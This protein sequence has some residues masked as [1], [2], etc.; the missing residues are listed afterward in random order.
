M[1]ISYD[2]YRVFYYVAQ[3]GNLSKAA[4]CLYSNQPNLTRAIKALESELGCP[5]FLRSNRGMRL[6]PEGERLYAHVRAAFAH[7][8]AG[9]AEL[10][11]SRDLESGTV[12]VAAS[13]VALRCVLLPVLRQYRRLYPGIRL[14]ISNHS[15]PQAIAALRG[16][17]ADIAVVTTPTVHEATLVE[18]PIRPFSEVA[19]CGRA[20][21]EL[22]GRKVS[23]AE[24]LSYPLVSLGA[25]TKSFEHYS[26]FFA[27]RGL[28]YAP[29]IE[30]ATADQILP[31]VAA[32]L[33]VGFVPEAFLP[34]VEGVSVIDLEEPLPTRRVCMIKRRD[35]P[36]GAAARQLERLL[37][38]AAEGAV[39]NAT[40]PSE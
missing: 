22:L 23:F 31:M 19:V 28:L 39:A 10:R 33:G 32:D 2:H 13:E 30:T 34:G 24:L 37:S 20:F 21:A 4:K 1:N 35:R 40:A 11:E 25:Q 38:Q 7:I 27:D 5:L 26:G 12:C 16:V 15:T 14:K 3:C 9:E 17:A 18:H 8:E 36:L 29:D 6:T